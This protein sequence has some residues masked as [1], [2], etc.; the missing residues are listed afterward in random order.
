MSR[1]TLA[2]LCETSRITLNSWPPIGDPFNLVRSV[3][4]GSLD[5]IS[6]TNGKSNNAG[7]LM[8]S[9]AVRS[10]QICRVLFTSGCGEEDLLKGFQSF[11]TKVP[12]LAGIFNDCV[13]NGEK[14]RQS[15]TVSIYLFLDIRHRYCSCLFLQVVKPVTHQPMRSSRQTKETDNQS[16][17]FVIT[18]E[19]SVLR[20]R[21]TSSRTNTKPVP[22]KPHQDN[23]PK[24]RSSNHSVSSYTK[25]VSDILKDVFSVSELCCA[26][27]SKPANYFC[28][29][30]Y[31]CM[32]YVQL[33]WFIIKCGFLFCFIFS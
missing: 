4:V 6:L 14:L 30:T 17:H 7:I 28:S 19:R 18:R 5:L 1:N 10:D 2:S 26:I 22:A 13:M 16:H 12:T 32:F 9:P 24:S 33:D 31:L 8:W 11:I 25:L 27:K 23:L 20:V 3:G 29:R 15:I 21:G